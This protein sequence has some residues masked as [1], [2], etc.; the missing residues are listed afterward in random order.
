MRVFD[1]TSDPLNYSFSYNPS[2]TAALSAA[3]F[4]NAS[5]TVEDLRRASLWKL[6]RILDIPSE[7]MEQLRMLVATDNLLADS[8]L[9]R[10][11]ILAL[12][13]CTGVGF[14]MA[15]TFL[16]FLRPDVFPIIDVRAYR[17]L[18]GKRLYP[19]SYSLK[20][21]LDYVKRIQE[22]AR[23][24]NLPLARIDEQL[25]CFDIH[26]NGRIKTQGSPVHL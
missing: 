18:T 13:E 21:Y 3:L 25:Y 1:P 24:T 15:S 5:V 20:L 7:T 10:Q 6:D 9:S 23:S 17:A 16:K 8:E 11:L 4:R 26:H 22:I 2:E 12:V 19:T 14:P